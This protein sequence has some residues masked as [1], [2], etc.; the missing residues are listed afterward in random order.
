MSLDQLTV[1]VITFNEEANIGRTLG[2]LRWAPSI[3]VIDS[4]STDSTLDIVQAYPNTRV[5]QRRFQ[6]FADQCNF[7]LGEVTTPWVLSIDADYVFP[8]ESQ[9]A[10]EAAIQGD[11]AAYRAMFRYCIYG[12]PVRGSILPPRIVLYRKARAHYVNDGHG[13]RVVVEGSV[14][15][16]PFSIHHDDRKPLSRWLQAQINYARQEA[17]KISSSPGAALG[18]NDRV[19]KAVV[20]AP[21]LVFLLVYILH[22]GFLSG[23]RGLF[24]ALQRLTAELLLSVFLID[25]RLQSHFQITDSKETE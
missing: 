13:H 21:P 1:M 25:M 24:Y 3:L 20:L 5:L 2:S 14:E 9:Q 16:L 23:W 7:G 8:Q 15:S 19:R 18:R 6:N 17:D 12:R 22:G 4:Y 10:I 11:A